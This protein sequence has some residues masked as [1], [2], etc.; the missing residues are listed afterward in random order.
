MKTKKELDLEVKYLEQDNRLLR[1]I[2][3]KLLQDFVALGKE[4]RGKTK[5]RILV[6]TKDFKA[7]NIT[8]STL[9]GVGIQMEVENNLTMKL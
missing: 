9:I 5:D 3:S 1:N 2:I 7:K 6:F 8:C 4:P